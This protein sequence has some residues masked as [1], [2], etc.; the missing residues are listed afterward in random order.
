MTIDEALRE[1]EAI[2]LRLEHLPADA[3]ERREL[4]QRRAQLRAAAR[5]AADEARDPSYLRLELEHLERRLAALE[6]RKIKIPR[7]QAAIK[8]MNDPAASINA[9]NRRLEDADAT[10]R[11]ALSARIE[12]LRLVL[13]R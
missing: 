11:A 2:R 3:V 4:E 9:I 5:Q 1:I 10:D 13:D 8:W 12:E 7:W 6:H